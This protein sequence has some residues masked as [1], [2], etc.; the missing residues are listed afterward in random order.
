MLWESFGFS[1]SPY[2]GEEL[3]VSEDGRSLFVGRRDESRRLLID[4]AERGG[5]TIVVG[6][7]S[8][9]G[10]T[11]FVN[12]NQ[13]LLYKRQGKIFEF[14]FELPWILPS[15]RKVQLQNGEQINTIF[16]KILSSI[17][18]SIDHHCKLAGEDFPSELSDVKT[19]LSQIVSKERGGS[20]GGQFAGFGLD[21]SHSRSVAIDDASTARELNLLEI[22]DRVVSIVRKTF[23]FDG[24]C[25]AVNN[26]E[27]LRQDYLQDTL[28]YFR[29]SLFVRDHIWWVLLGPEDL[30]RFIE[31][32][33]PRLTG[34]VG[35]G[36][37]AIK[38]L[39][40]DHLG[41]ILELRRIKLAIPG[42]SPKLPIPED[43]L[44]FL[45]SA[46]NGDLRFT[47]MIA[48]E[49]VKGLMYEFPSLAITKELA[50][51][52]IAKIVMSYFEQLNFLPNQAR[53][54]RTLVRAPDDRYLPSQCSKFGYAT[55]EEFTAALDPL[56]E[57]RLLWRERTTGGENYYSARGYLELGKRVDVGNYLLEN[58]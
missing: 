16:L 2:F 34:I 47:F 52:S 53:L 12:V 32:N 19:Y 29:D 42:Q 38:P 4:F 56:V 37:I 21:F 30:S 57:R 26:L 9:A 33:V 11:S 49:V 3:E 6:G 46:S 45:Y 14:N 58:N 17:I 24:V 18:F 39:E 25:V 55:A 27:I 51:R 54:V 48:N 35:G 50:I 36:S 22:M 15:F 8:G 10:K 5:S 20:I 7:V 43:V 40:I 1:K 23:G 31:F 41:E 44:E 28:N 13:F